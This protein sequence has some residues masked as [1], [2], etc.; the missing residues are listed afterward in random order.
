MN[1][2]VHICVGGLL[3]LDGKAHKAEQWFVFSP[4]LKGCY[5]DAK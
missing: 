4:W 3:W 1:G 5:R 2:N